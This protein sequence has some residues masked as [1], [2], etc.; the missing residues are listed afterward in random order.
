MSASCVAFC[1]SGGVYTDVVVNV[2]A[3]GMIRWNWTL[4]LPDKSPQHQQHG[5]FPHSFCHF[6]VEKGSREA[7]ANT[8]KD[9]VVTLLIVYPTCGFG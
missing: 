7:K 2:L 6:I 5:S 8:C 4:Q 3:S 1:T 9:L